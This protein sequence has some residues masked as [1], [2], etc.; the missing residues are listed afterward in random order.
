MPCDPLREDCLRLLVN[1]IARDHTDAYS[2]NEHVDYVINTYAENPDRLI[3]T[4]QER[5]AHLVALAADKLDYHVAFST[6]DNEDELKRQE[7]SVIHD[8]K[9]AIE[10]DSTNWDARRM[11]A[12]LELDSSEEFLTFLQDNLNEVS[13]SCFATAVKAKA[14]AFDEFAR[15]LPLY[16]YYRWLYTIAARSFDCGHYHSSLM[17]AQSLLHTNPDDYTDVRFTAALAMAKLEVDRQELA[18]FR[19]NHHQAYSVLLPD[20]NSQPR[21]DDPWM[22]IAELALAWKSFD[23]KSAEKTLARLLTLTPHAAAT[24]NLQ[25]VVPD[26]VYARLCVPINSDDELALAVS[27]ADPLLQEG[28]GTPI[29]APFASWLGEHDLVLQALEADPDWHPQTLDFDPFGSGI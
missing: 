18:Q 20:G 9:E 13:R 8:L 29:A 26:G 7:E 19:K 15:D 23:M 4:D 21:P 17:I 24:L 16:P 25:A 2:F 14:H 6:A 1:H 11:L 27:E 3:V 5:A 28:I 10:L 12:E 22:L